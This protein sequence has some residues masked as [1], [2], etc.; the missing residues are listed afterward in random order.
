MEKRG[1]DFY[2][3]PEVF[4]YYIDHRSSGQ[5]PNENIEQ[6]ILLDL[7]GQTKELSVLDLGC[8]DARISKKFKDLGAKKYL[9][10]EGSKRMFELA[11][12]NIEFE[13]SE[14]QL[15]WLEDFKST[16]E[17]FDLIISSL[18]FHYIEDLKLLFQKLHETLAPKGR[19]IFSVE[20]PV[21][22]SNNENLKKSPVREAWLVD[23]YFVRGKREDHW[24]G[25][26]VTKYH[27]TIEDYLDLLSDSGFSLLRLRE[28]DPPRST[29][30]DISL[31]ERRRRIPLFLFLAA[32]KS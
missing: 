24:M 16:S 27:R 5:A 19:L 20:H 18:A 29:F 30:Q 7:I 26:V 2:D 9:G 3:T 8:G 1:P 31:W 10:I 14:V 17:K 25:D 22:T 6:P 13:F 4:Q 15:A 32:Q 12:K 23:N 28:S 11:Q 21:I